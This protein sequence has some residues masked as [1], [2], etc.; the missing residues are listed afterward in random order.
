[1]PQ[2]AEVLSQDTSSMSSHADII[3]FKSAIWALGH[4]GSAAGGLDL[5]VKEGVVAQLVE[6]A[7]TCPVLSIRG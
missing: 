7:E 3:T 4:I 5:L 6:L 1:M 2:F